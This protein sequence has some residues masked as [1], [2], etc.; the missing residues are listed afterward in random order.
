[1]KVLLLAEIDTT[2]PILNLSIPKMENGTLY[3]QIMMSGKME[4]ALTDV[5]QPRKILIESDKQT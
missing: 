5:Q 2:Q 1:M 3:K 4:D